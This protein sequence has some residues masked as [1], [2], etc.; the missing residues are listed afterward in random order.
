MLKKFVN[1][2]QLLKAQ[3]EVIAAAKEYYYES[4]IYLHAAKGHIR[5][6]NAMNNLKIIES[7]RK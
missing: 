6:K 5:F 1:Y 2:F 4:P 3:K 7:E